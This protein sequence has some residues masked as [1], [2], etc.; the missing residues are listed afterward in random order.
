M[1]AD[2]ISETDKQMKR[3]GQKNMLRTV[4]VKE[5]TAA[6]KEMC[7][8]ANHFLSDDMA[9]RMKKAVDEEESPLGK[10]ILTQLQENLQIAGDDMIPICQ[11]TGMAVVFIKLPIEMD[12][13]VMSSIIW[14]HL[15]Q[16]KEDQS[17]LQV[18][19]LPAAW[20]SMPQI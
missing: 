19:L 15:R 9:A 1:S 20:I 17:V 7:I 4:N 16:G 3:S 10:Q 2:F 11:D 6:I 18:R 13:T 12:R 8:E 14:N 5:V